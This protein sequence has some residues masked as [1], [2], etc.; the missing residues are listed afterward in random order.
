M[1]EMTLQ[2][3]QVC[4]PNV[5]ACIHYGQDWISK[6]IS[7]KMKYKFFNK[8]NNFLPSFH[9][10]SSNKSHRTLT[11]FG[12]IFS[13]YW[14]ARKFPANPVAVIGN[15]KIAMYAGISLW[16]L[17]NIKCMKRDWLRMKKKGERNVVMCSSG[18]YDVVADK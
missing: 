4:R 5:P 2:F 18:V 15:M 11:I 3:V 6:H 16:M 9:P 8:M 14:Y 17:L 1:D 10:C 13:F 7:L 12:V